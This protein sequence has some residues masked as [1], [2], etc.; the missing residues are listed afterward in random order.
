[1]LKD[2]CSCRDW[3]EL[4]TNNSDVFKWHL[5]VYGWIIAW[6]EL[7]EENGYTQIHKYGVKIHYCPFCGK[8]LET[9]EDNDAK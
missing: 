9:V 5:P 1:M 2:F 3:K 4:K 8:K 7:T 6:K